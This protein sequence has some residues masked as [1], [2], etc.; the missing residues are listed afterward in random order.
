MK[1]IKNTILALIAVLFIACDADNK[2]T[3]GFYLTDAPANEGIVA[4][5]V[6]IQSVRYSINDE[7][8]IDVAINPVVV[9]LLDFSN[10]ADTLLSNI[11]LDEGLKVSQVRLIL[12]DNNTIEFADGTIIPVKTPSAQTS[13]LKLN[14]QSFA[15]VH[16]GY[17]VV[18][19]F[20]A[21]RSIVKQGNGSY[22]LKPVI[23]SYIAV[24]SSSIYGTI[25]PENVATK[26]FTVDMQGDTI[27]TLSDTLQNNLF[28]LH[29]LNT[30][31]YDIMYQDPESG[32]TLSLQPDVSVVGGFDVNL[33]E[34]TL[35]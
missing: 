3:V 19:D 10:G 11:E 28:V 32:E 13:G 24:N 23:R 8:W 5:N 34:L 17:K 9:N 29:G 15:E 21:S 22:L 18:I 33:G 30:G 2:Q 6:D 1:T 20:D 26:I 12:G 7:D 27:A 14:V 16:S 25:K 35:P 4:V 31:T